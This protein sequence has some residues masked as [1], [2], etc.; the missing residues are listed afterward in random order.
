MDFNCLKCS[1][2]VFSVS[3]TQNNDILP[4]K[5]KDDP[6]VTDSKPVCSQPGI[7]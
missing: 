5:V 3:H 7:C 6:V 2:D 1:V 4:L